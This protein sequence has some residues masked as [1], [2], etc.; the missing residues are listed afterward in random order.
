MGTLAKEP[1]AL[2]LSI[3]ALYGTARYLTH[4]R[5]RH[6][7]MAGLSLGGLAMTRLE[8]GWVITLALGAGLAWWLVARVRR[9]T[10]P[11]GTGIPRRCVLICAVGL[12]ACVPW[13]VYTYALTHQ[14]FYWGNSGGIS[15][16]WMSSPSPSQLGQ[17]H[18]VHTV[19][20]DPVLAGYRPFFHYLDTLTPLQRDLELQHVAVV[21]AVAHPAKYALNILANL[22]RMFAAFP[23]SFRLPAADVAG[24]IVVNGAL[25]GGLIAAAASLKRRR[26]SLPREA[27]P[28]LLF[29]AVAFA[30]HVFPT[31]EPRMLL[32]LIPVPIWLI[33]QTFDRRTSKTLINPARLQSYRSSDLTSRAA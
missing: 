15:L 19:R 18:A 20:T 30:V 27:A 31:A 22:G 12:L 33:A 23:F 10:A 1:L 29:A 6:A 21:Q 32:P 26:P 25:L 3:S 13:L 4:G 28:F 17:W 5:S 7:L 16:Y 24:A 2:L 11:E 9:R 8:Y 14:V